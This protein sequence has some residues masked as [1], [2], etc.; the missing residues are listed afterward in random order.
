MRIPQGPGAQLDAWTQA[1]RSGALRAE[2]SAAGGV[3]EG[4]AQAPSV[5]PGASEASGAPSFGERLGQLVG[6]V[7]AM[8]KAADRAATEFAEGRTHDIHGTLVTLGKADVAFRLLGAVRNR[9][10]E[11]YREIMRMGA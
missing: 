5:V 7:D 11:A 9:A 4:A 3:T 2:R 10:L 1:L 6:E 8:Q